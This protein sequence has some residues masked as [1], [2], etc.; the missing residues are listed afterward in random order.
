MRHLLPRPRRRRPRPRHRTRIGPR[1]RPRRRR[2]I[3]PT[4]R[5]RGIAPRPRRARSRRRRRVTAA[6]ARGGGVAPT[7]APSSLV[8][9]GGTAS[10]ALARSSSF[11]RSA[12]GRRA[13]GIAIPAP[14][15]PSSRAHAP[16]PL[17][18]I[19]V[20]RPAVISAASIAGR[21]AVA[22]IPLPPPSSIAEVPPARTGET[23]S[24]MVHPAPAVEGAA[25]RQG[26]AGAS[27]AS[28]H[29]G[30]AGGGAG[31]AVA[32]ASSSGV[33]VGG[34]GIGVV[35][36]GRAAVGL[37]IAV[38]AVGPADFR[39][40]LGTAA[41]VSVL[42]VTLPGMARGL[43]RSPRARGVAATVL[44][45]RATRST[46]LR[47]SRRG[48]DAGMLTSD[49]LLN[50]FLLGENFAKAGFFVVGFGG[51]LG[52]VVVGC[53][54]DAVVVAGV[55]VGFDGVRAIAVVGAVAFL[56]RFRR[57]AG[58]IIFRG[59]RRIMP[60]LATTAVG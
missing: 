35:G 21:A 44:G 57:A 40:G 31:S 28:S 52:I 25:V 58:S 17:V 18:P 3:A 37:A 49:L 36:V 42:R 47:R 22:T 10:G 7:A 41:G 43:L 30:V 2:R 9:E 24:P 53:A 12:G 23:S 50:Y 39:I 20:V 51:T 8:R 13:A 19:S 5:P 48:I 16:I 56:P 33:V 26:R 46:A 6:G 14:S 54:V 38:D 4:P 55:G 15:P 45:G 34:V 27:D 60:V 1:P 32:A 59:F 11:S 29:S